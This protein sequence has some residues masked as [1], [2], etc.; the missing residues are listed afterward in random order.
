MAISQATISLA[1]K[2]KFRGKAPKKPKRSASLGQ[3]EKYLQRVKDYEK[4]VNEYAARTRKKEALLK[5]IF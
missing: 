5:K 1:R 4:K 2:S 3:L